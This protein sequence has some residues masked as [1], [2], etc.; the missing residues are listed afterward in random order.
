MA[1]GNA[2][3][4][5]QQS[6]LGLF[7]RSSETGWELVNIAYLLGGLFLLS[8]RVISWHIPLSIV[9]TVAVISGIFYSPNSSAVFGTP[10]L[11]LFGSATMVGAFF[12]ATDPVSA[13]TTPLGRVVYGI[14]IGIA[15]YSVRVWGSYLD[16]IAIAVLFG[17]FCAPML[18]HFCR[19]R[20]Y[21][22]SKQPWLRSLIGTHR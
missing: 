8:M 13:A 3:L 22:H 7:Q 5:A 12:I 9:I 4:E 1:G 21:G 6:G 17:N 16:S 14:L 2:I 15:I 20:I 11:H 19:P 18:D 10:Y